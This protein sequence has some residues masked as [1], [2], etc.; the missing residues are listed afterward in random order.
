MRHLMEAPESPS[1]LVLVA[2]ARLSRILGDIAAVAS[3]HPP[4]AATA[5]S[6]HPASLLHVKGLRATLKDIMAT[7]PDDILGR[8]KFLGS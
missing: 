8:S 7:T 6:V 5:Q 2:Q 3:W 1:D 4:E